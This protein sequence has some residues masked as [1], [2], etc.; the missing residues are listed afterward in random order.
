MLRITVELVRGGREHSKRVL[1][2]ADVANMSGL[3]DVSDYA[4]EVETEARLEPW[5]PGWERRG[6][7]SGHGRD[8]SVWELVAKVSAWAAKEAEKQS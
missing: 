7:I 8:K 1:A 5:Q 4:V 6:M 3:A 2:K